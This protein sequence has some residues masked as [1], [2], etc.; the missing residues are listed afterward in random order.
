MKL[1][2]THARLALAERVEDVVQLLL[3]QREVDCIGRD[4][5]LGILDEV[6]EL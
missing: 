5:R 1:E 3:Q 4:D 6:T 2:V